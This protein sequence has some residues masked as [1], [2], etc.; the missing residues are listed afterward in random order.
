MSEKCF[1]NI[2]SQSELWIFIF[3]SVFF[4]EPTI[5]VLIQFNLPTF[6]F[7]N[8]DLGIVFKNITK[9]KGTYFS[10][11]FSYRSCIGLHFILKVR[12]LY[13]LN[14]CER[15][16]VC[17]YIHLICIWKSWNCSISICWKTALSLLS[18]LCKRSVAYIC[19]TLFSGSSFCSI[20]L[21]CLFFCQTMLSERAAITCSELCLLQ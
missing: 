8:C 4:V 21:F 15:C 13:R 14:F 5:Q 16:K 11:P 3:L 17:I 20:D 12:D 2:F 19:L 18:F 9:P 10:P 6:S 1:A 7:M